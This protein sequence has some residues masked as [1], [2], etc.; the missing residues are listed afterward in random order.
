MLLIQSKAL[1]GFGVSVASLTNI[2]RVVGTLTQLRREPD[3]ESLLKTGATWGLAAITAGGWIVAQGL[4]E[5]FIV[6]TKPCN[7]AQKNYDNLLLDT[8]EE[9]LQAITDPDEEARASDN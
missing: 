1:K 3:P 5:R 2:Y 4:F 9:V 8:R 7:A 6:N